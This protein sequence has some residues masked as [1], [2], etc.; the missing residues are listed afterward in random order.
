MNVILIHCL[1]S[2]YGIHGAS[3]GIHID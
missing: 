2:R 3:N 1:N